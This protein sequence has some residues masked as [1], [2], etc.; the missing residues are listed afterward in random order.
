MPPLT[1]YNP[2]T[3][4][5]I[6]DRLAAGESLRQICDPETRD[7][8][9]PGRTTVLAWLDEQPEFRAKYARARE[10]QADAMDDKI[11]SVADACTSEDAAAARVKIDAY[12][13]RASKLAPKKYG[14]SMKLVGDADQPIAIQRIERVIVD[15]KVTK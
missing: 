3:A 15:P 9:M 14:D 2:E 11:L 5:E 12:K 10:A 4:G 8:F 13:W 6:C 1:T 7:D